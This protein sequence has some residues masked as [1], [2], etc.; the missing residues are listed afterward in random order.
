[1]TMN[2][3]NVKKIDDYIAKN[4]DSKLPKTHSVIIKG[5]NKDIQVYKIP[6]DL[7]FYNIKNG[8]FAA[9]Y[10]EKIEKIGRDLEPDKTED[11]KIIQKMLLELDPRKSLELESDI[12]KYGQREPGISTHDGYIHNGNRRMSVIQ[13][14]VDTGNIDANFLQVARLPPN[15]DEQDLWLI[16]AGIQLS[17]NVQLDYG[18]INTLLKFK[19]GIDSGLTP[20]QVAKNLYGYGDEKQILEKLEILKLIVKYLKF[21]G[22][23]NHF[24][25]ADR[26]VEHFIDLNKIIGTEKRKGA[27]FDALN[28]YQNIG[29]QLIHDGVT[30]R[31]LRAMK[32]IVVEEK[33]RTQLL[34]ALEH[35]KPEPSQKKMETKMKAEADEI[36]TPA[37]ILFNEARDTATAITSSSKPLTNLERA[38]T[39]LDTI[40]GKNSSVSEAEFQK[41][42]ERLEK[43]INKLKR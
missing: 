6:L 2:E 26:I 14:I 37:V 40:D 8:R 35:S 21:I 9:E 36:N 4:P 20:I 34:K 39:N 29:F 31:D 33:S 22:E 1:M 12:K 41:L 7:L 38:F 23:P 5:E 42:L 30:Q 13:N 11:K 43:I 32:K 25:K 10:L 19:E 16:E 17:K 28:A 15:V 24:K 27:T 18:P 3:G